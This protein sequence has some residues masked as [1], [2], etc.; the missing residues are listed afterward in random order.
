MQ[1]YYHSSSGFWIK[2]SKVVSNV[3][4]PIVSLFIF[5]SYRC[6]RNHDILQAIYI[7]ILLLGSVVFPL[8]FW[9]VW[10]VKRG[11]YTDLDVSERKQRNSLYAF[12]MLL[13]AVYSYLYYT[14]FDVFDKVVF[15]LFILMLVM[16]FSNFFIKS[17][18]HTAFNVFTALLF[19]ME[20][21]Y[22]GV[23][24]GGIGVA[25]GVSRV[26]LKR[27]SPWEVIMGWFIALLIGV[28]YIEIR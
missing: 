15:F 1:G 9:L 22:I 25:V 14:W 23:L 17:S 24:W 26:I 16:H 27:H 7:L 11:R 18:M 4:N 6:F 13:V 20:N 19:Y 12:S 2:V 5:Y 3:F 28:I 8:V 10:N 21:V